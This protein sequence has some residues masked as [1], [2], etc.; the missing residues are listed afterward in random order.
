MGETF[1]IDDCKHELDMVERVAQRLGNIPERMINDC[2]FEAW[3]MSHL[4]ALL[5]S[6]DSQWDVFGALQLEEFVTTRLTLASSFFSPEDGS[7]PDAVQ[8]L[9]NSV[10]EPLGNLLGSLEEDMHFQTMKHHGKC[11]LA[12]KVDQVNLIAGSSSQSKVDE[13][14]LRLL[15]ACSAKVT[16]AVTLK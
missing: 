3:F 7:E 9:M 16:N 15:I 13:H 8:R 2:A 4:E 14:E 11:A 6:H 12:V 10:L 5:K 1:S